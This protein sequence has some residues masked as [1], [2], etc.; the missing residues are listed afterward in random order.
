[1][2]T[3]LFE[4]LGGEQG[5][6][7][8]ANDVVDLHRVNPVISARFAQSDVSALKESVA[9]FFI[10]GSG[11]PQVYTGPN[12]RSAHQSM[13]IADNEYMAAVDDV[14]QALSNNGIGDAEK[15]EVLYIFYNLR[16]DVVGV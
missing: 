7:N 16:P 3:S 14:M 5:I 15:A 8:I 11:G 10:A 6:R 1:M 9:T 2:D 4:R 12:M 13:N